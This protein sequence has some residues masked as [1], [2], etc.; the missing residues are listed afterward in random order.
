[1]NVPM[2]IPNMAVDKRRLVPTHEYI[3]IY[4]LLNQKTVRKLWIHILYYITYIYIYVTST[5]EIDATWLK[6][7]PKS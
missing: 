1:M 5:I 2:P 6:V 3:K 7:V 4:K